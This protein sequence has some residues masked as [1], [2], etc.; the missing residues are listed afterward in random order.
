MKEFEISVTC[1]P[2]ADR[3][4]HFIWKNLREAI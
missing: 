3:Y 4:L 2:R 1:N